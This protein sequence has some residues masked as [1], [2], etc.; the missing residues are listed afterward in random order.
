MIFFRSRTTPGG[1]SG[2]FPPSTRW[3]VNPTP[4]YAASGGQGSPRCESYYMP[5]TCRTLVARENYSS[6][7]SMC[8]RSTAAA[9]RS[10][11]FVAMVTA[12]ALR[13]K[14]SGYQWL[15][16]SGYP[17]IK[18][19]LSGYQNPVIRLSK[20]GYP[21]IKIRLSGYQNPV[22]RLSK[23]GYPVIK[24]RLS[25]YQNPVIRL[26]KSGYPVIKSTPVINDEWG[27]VRLHLATLPDTRLYSL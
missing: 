5:S 10:P 27:L 21:V 6:W 3:V 1:L 20:S 13:L 25:G 24:I 7:C 18:I 22:I 2:N 12:K 26:S 9:V 17:V 15:S 16:K 19:R 11:V 14:H 23:S 4:N 8:Y